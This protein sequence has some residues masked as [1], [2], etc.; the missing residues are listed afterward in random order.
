MVIEEK[1]ARELE[2]LPR[3]IIARIQRILAELERWPAVSGCKPLR[4]T[5][6]G[7]YRRRTGDYRISFRVQ[8]QRVIIERIGHRDGFYE[9]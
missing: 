4:G 6:A 2:R 7:H 5:L 9:D 8:G 1:A 3:P